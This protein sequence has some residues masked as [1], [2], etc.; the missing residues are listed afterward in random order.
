M[1]NNLMCP[2]DGGVGGQCVYICAC[3]CIDTPAVHVYVCVCVDVCTFISGLS[4]IYIYSACAVSMRTYV[5]ELGICTGHM[6]S[7][8]VC[9]RACALRLFIYIGCVQCMWTVYIFL[10]TISICMRDGH[11]LHR[12]LYTCVCRIKYDRSTK[13][14]IHTERRV[15]NY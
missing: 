2:R 8:C 14:L 11:L 6:F 9:S 3:V 13:N 12:Y 10:Y 4:H 5:P 7:V 1:C 15:G